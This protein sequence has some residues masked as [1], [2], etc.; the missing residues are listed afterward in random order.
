MTWTTQAL[1]AS[2]PPERAD[3]LFFSND[4]GGMLEGKRVCLSCPVRITCALAAEA[5]ETDRNGRPIGHGIYGIWG[6]ET[7]A[8]RRERRFRARAYRPNARTRP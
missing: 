5:A 2:L 3:H 4:P 7:P 8:E 1:C 6:G